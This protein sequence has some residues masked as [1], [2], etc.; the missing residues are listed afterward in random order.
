M[1]TSAKV[2]T[3]AA[4]FAKRG[5]AQ[6]GSAPGLGPGG[7]R[8][9]SCRPDKKRR[10]LIRASSFL[11]TFIKFQPMAPFPKRA[12]VLPSF[13][14]TSKRLPL[15]FQ[16]EQTSS[17]PFPKRANVFPS[18]PK[19][20]KRPPLLFQSEQTSSPPFPKEGQG[21]FVKK[22]VPTSFLTPSLGRAGVGIK[23]WFVKK[24][25]QPLFSLPPFGRARVGIR[26]GK[27]RSYPFRIPS[28]WE[29]QGGY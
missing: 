4:E 15:L 8:F 21:W 10:M 1:Q 9:E 19:T 5:V 14:K 3:F 22:N 29:A 11:Y 28:L 20:S 24:M 2:C 17:P 13:P 26:W 27:K 18:F 25:S 6:S 12:N 23:G 7:R 16:N